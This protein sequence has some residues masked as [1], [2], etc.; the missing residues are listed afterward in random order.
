MEQNEINE[1]LRNTMLNLNFTVP[2]NVSM[3]ACATFRQHGQPCSVI[4]FFLQLIDFQC[5]KKYFDY[6]SKIIAQKLDR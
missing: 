2:A 4:I 6:L 3:T 5:L 1:P